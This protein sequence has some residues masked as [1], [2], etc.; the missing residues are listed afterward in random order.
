MGYDFKENKAKVQFRKIWK[1]E[2]VKR[3]KGLPNGNKKVF[4]KENKKRK[5]KGKKQGLTVRK[6]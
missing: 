6:Q 2:E 4:L 1:T 5:N 3:I